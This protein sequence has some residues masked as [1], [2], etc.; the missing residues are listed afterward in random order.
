MNLY[1]IRDKKADVVMAPFAAPT[2]GVACR[3]ILEAFRDASSMVSKYPSDYELIQVGE[4]DE[5]TGELAPMPA[6][7]V[8]QVQV[9]WESQQLRVTGQ[10][11]MPQE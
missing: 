11:S 6:R 5:K 4:Y 10:L 9:L 1:T 3:S 8:V 7:L 2:D